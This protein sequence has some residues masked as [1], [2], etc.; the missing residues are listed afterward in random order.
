MTKKRGVE[1][2]IVK[3]QMEERQKERIKLPV[4]DQPP[5]KRRIGGDLCAGG[6]VPIGGST[7]HNAPRF[8][9]TGSFSFNRGRFASTGPVV[10]HL[11]VC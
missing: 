3:C 9:I 7:W 11:S 8:W 1:E 5:E 6:E 10:R 4:T 2:E